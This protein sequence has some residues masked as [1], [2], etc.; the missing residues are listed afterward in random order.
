VAHQTVSSRH[1]LS[2]QEFDFCKRH[3]AGLPAATAYRRAFLKETGTGATFASLDANGN[4][5]G[6]ELD[7]KEV[8]R[9]ASTLLKQDYI[10][11]YL[12]EIANPAGDHARGVLLEKALFEG[13]R[14]AA[15]TILDQEDKLGARDAYE[16]WATVMCA[17]GTEVVVDLPGGGEAVVPLKGLFPQFADAL[18]PPDVVRKTI[19]TLEAYLVRDGLAEE[20]V[21]DTEVPTP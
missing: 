11:A 1:A 18:P 15:Q 7:S 20:E 3:L 8:S 2:D 21:P 12:A 9:R 6:P 4:G 17:I 19:A 5:V 16:H 13:D 14:M 10:K